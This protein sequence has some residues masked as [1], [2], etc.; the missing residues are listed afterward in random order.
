VRPGGGLRR[1]RAP[2]LAILLSLPAPLAAQTGHY[3]PDSLINVR[4]IPRETP[5]INVI[6]RMRTIASALG[7]HCSYCHMGEEGRP[8][9][10]YD[11]ASDERRTKRAAREMLRMVAAIDSLYLPRIP[12]RPEPVRT[13]TCATCHRGTAR[14]T[15]LAT[16]MAEIAGAAGADSA[17]RAYHDLRQRYFGRDAY[18]FGEP[19][20]SI[21]AY[22]LGR[23]GKFAEAFTLLQLNDSLF[24]QSSALQV[25]RGNIELM[26]GDTA[27]AAEAFR[28]AVRRDPDNR[29]A[30]GRLRDIG[31][32]P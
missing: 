9:A 17:R 21:A 19:S 11:F 1:V 30:A 15:P 4:V 14:P 6:G 16:L 18:D 25:F 23:Q 28:L 12:D 27:A 32:G 29:E 10:T 2:L 31:R 26:R 24:P 22:R 13:V 3:P 20:L 5:V 8:L 7:V